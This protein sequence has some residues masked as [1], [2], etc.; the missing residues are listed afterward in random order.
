MRS[1][2]ETTFPGFSWH[3]SAIP[4]VWIIHTS[5]H[6]AISLCLLADLRLNLYFICNDCDA[7]N[8]LC[9]A[10]PGKI[11]VIFSWRG[12]HGS[13]LQE[14]RG[15][16]GP[17]SLSII[18]RVPGKCPSWK[19]EQNLLV[20]GFS[21]NVGWASMPVFPAVSVQILSLPVPSALSLT[22]KEKETIY[23]GRRL[24]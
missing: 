24:L 12:T 21:R 19:R 9:K 15:G 8:A 17:Y 16:E 18:V 1:Q 10:E 3:L 4:D 11:W 14:K 22:E 5:C 7:V 20:V 6:V 23:A 13:D 2:Q